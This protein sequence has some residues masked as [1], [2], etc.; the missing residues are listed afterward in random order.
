[1]KSESERK[2]LY[3]AMLARDKKF[4]GRFY[5]GV[6]TT[7]IYCRPICPA[8][9]L[10][11]NIE[12]LRSPAE[13]EKLLYRACKRCRPDIS[14]NTSLWAGTQS[15][16]SRALKM[17][18]E[19][20][21]DELGLK[22]FSDKLGMSE[23][24]LRRLFDEHLGA[25]PIQI[26]I[27][28]RLSLAKIMLEQNN[29]SITEL[30][31]ASGFSSVRRFNEAFLQKYR[32]SPSQF[33]KTKKEKV[34]MSQADFQ[35]SIKYLAPYN[36]GYLMHFFSRHAN[37]G[38]EF[39]SENAYQRFTQIEDRNILIEVTNNTK[40]EQL[41]I[42]IYGAKSKDLNSLITKIK[43]LF[44]TEH[45]PYN[46]EIAKK[47]KHLDGIRV[48][49]SFDTFET[50]IGIILGQLVSVEQ[51]QKKIAKLIETYG[52]A[53]Q[54]QNKTYYTF[55]SPEVLM[56]AD[57]FDIGLT[58]VR[59]HSIRELS[60]L[61][62]QKEIILDSSSDANKSREKL[63]AIKGIGPWTVEM[64]AMRCLKDTNAFPKNDL[65]I[66]RAIE[67]LGFQQKA[68]EPWQAYLTNWVWYK[69]ASELSKKTKKT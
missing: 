66:Q 12:F 27:S 57:L 11:K 63:L 23:R 60:K 42:A 30:A 49:G 50:A 53:H 26:S 18:H 55:P 38:I 29:V 22:N 51:A 13:A 31:F 44:D 20:Q 33:K 39:F 1:M 41:D 9:P 40:A 15:S 64:I 35:L 32:Q 10:L 46:L 36:W 56:Q 62:H 16:I 65:I 5:I 67:Q 68:F 25:S 43:N 19:G 58:K 6:K 59:V 54:Y 17:I 2:K 47:W 34:N 52:R 8:R 21:L 14:P 3:K 28:H 37:T 69:Y 45:N 7:K 24:H 48:P 61:I 4:D